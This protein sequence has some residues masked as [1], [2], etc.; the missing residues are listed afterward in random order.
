MAL[1]WLF[2]TFYE[3]KVLVAHLEHG[4]RGEESLAD[5]RFVE[6][7]AGRW[8]LEAQVGH[9][10][11]PG[12]LR[13]GESLEAGARRVRLAFLEAAARES[14]AWGVALGHNREDV[15]ETV[16]F[17]LCRGAGA[18]GAAGIPER[19]GIF[20]R[21][22]LRCSR[23][24]LRAILSQRGISWRED[25]TNEESD[26]TRNFIRN[27]LI[28]L[29][30]NKINKKAIDHLV[31][32][33]EEMRYYREE[34]EH[35]G[36]SLYEAV[37]RDAAQGEG[38]SHDEWDR[39]NIQAL[40]FRERARLVRALGRRRGAPALS[41]ERCEGLARLM[42]G[43]GRFELQWGGGMFVLGDRETVKMRFKTQDLRFKN[44]VG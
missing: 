37:R 29:I 25:R 15:A 35:L 12:L 32:F 9:A 16:L 30:E 39:E 24:F 20:F 26:V 28:P 19:R 21:P 27:Q 7:A 23:D 8:G 5:A 31:A 14:Q 4:I 2:R 17:N 34:E 18:W 38:G 22:L 3:G 10:P 11:V 44:R 1:L 43:S 42:E 40:S 36:A 41:R 33:S 13:R 6:E